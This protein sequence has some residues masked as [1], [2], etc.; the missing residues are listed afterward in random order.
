MVLAVALASTLCC[1]AQEMPQGEYVRHTVRWYEDLGSI[2]AQ[3]GVPR[4]VLISINSLGKDGKV[5][6]RQVLLIPT[7]E[8]YW[9]KLTSAKEE[10][11]RPAEDEEE[12]AQQQEE[13][14][15]QEELRRFPMPTNRVS[16]A[17]WMPLGENSGNNLDF[18]DGVLMGVREMGEDG[19]NVSLSAL[20]FDK[21]ARLAT[22]IE[23]NDFILG[24]VRASQVAEALDL[25]SGEAVLVSPL[26][27]KADSLA[28]T[29]ANLFQAPSQA[30]SF[31]ERA[32]QWE[33]EQRGDTLNTNWILVSSDAD[34]AFF[35]EAKTVLDSAKIS[36]SVCWC[37]VSDEI[38][39]LGSAYDSQRQNA[40][41]LAINSEACLNNAIRNMGIETANG[42][43]NICTYAC[44][45]AV[46]YET[47]PVE[48]LHKARLHVLCPYYIDY[49]ERSTLDFI[50]A[51]RA[52][53]NREPS[54]F[55]FQGHDLA[56]YMIRSRAKYGENWKYLIQDE[57]Q[58]DF[59]QASFKL[60][61]KGDGGG[62]VNVGMR[63]CI[64]DEDFGVRLLL[65]E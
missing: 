6:T 52:L 37:G 5:T 46:S 12:A 49:A 2:S 44:S 23:S 11:E 7:S 8:K 65:S 13:A 16:M 25:L 29:H 41:I 14:A 60:E 9:P 39:G 33:I 1:H 30:S 50:H 21:D 56:C 19:I 58:M 48:N 15:A 31:C 57:P 3:Y 4:D 38:S 63:R 53:F 64:Y 40:V 59:L 47:I 28:A 35:E 34:R 55:A 26:D 18:Y 22:G 61:R 32:V 43:R 20:D 17:L 45:K 27:H 24:P 51:Y 10:E 62:F 42:R 54:Q 36:Y